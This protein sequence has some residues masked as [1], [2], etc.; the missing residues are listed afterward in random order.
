VKN[1]PDS[2]G[3]GLGAAA[4]AVVT[5]SAILAATSVLVAE[6]G[7]AALD[8]TPPAA[9]IAVPSPG[10][11]VSN[12]YLTGSL[13]LTVTGI[14]TDTNLNNWTLDYGAGASPSSWT[15]I[16]TGT[17]PVSN[18]AL[19]TWQT[20]SL[21]NGTYTVRLQVWDKAGTRSVV[22][23]TV[24][25]GNF[26]VSQNVL[27]LNGSSGG[28]VTY[29]SVVPFTLTE[30]LVVK[31]EQ[32]QVVRTL[33]NLERG[34]G[35]YQ[36]SWDGRNDG[37]ALVPDGP[38]F[39]VATATAGSNSMTWDLTTQYLNNYFDSKEL[40]RIDPFDPFNNRP[41]FISYDF[42]VAGNVTISVFNKGL[43][44]FECDQPPRKALC[45][46]NRSYEESGRHTFVW[47]G[48][49]ATGVYRANFYSLLSVTTIRDRF[50][51]NAVVLFGTKPTVQNVAVNPPAFTVGSTTS[52]VAFA[53]A[54]YQHQ[55]ADITVTFLNQSSL[56][57]LRTITLP[58]QPPGQIT[59]PWDGR[60]DNG[61][62]VAPGFYTITVTATDG[63][64]N[65]VQGQILAT[66][67]R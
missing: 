23:N 7:T 33:V 6:P 15:A 58:T 9:V 57:T 64:G 48:V 46:V 19:G 11:V 49:D 1:L 31:N 25:L 54:T 10:Q 32:G 38:Y 39:Y 17:T 55:A 18:A 24:T 40:P 37:G 13:N 61:A 4:F 65:Q 21:A 2:I 26:T 8:A 3:P 43:S 53:L 28:T 14:A 50:A 30:T 47:A 51:R 5:V 35:S 36:D 52:T 41:M 67:R 62:F 27:Q 20:G 34:A 12:V 42:P 22:T 16:A 45:L 66:V 56:S 63:I 29:T 60:A 44:S 59:V